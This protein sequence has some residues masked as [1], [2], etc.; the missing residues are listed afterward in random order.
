[1]SK[2][3]KL[4]IAVL[5]VLAISANIA[6]IKHRVNEE[7]RKHEEYIKRINYTIY[8]QAL[9]LCKDEEIYSGDVPDKSI[10]FD[11]NELMMR[12]AYFNGVMG[13]TGE[14]AITTDD[15][16]RYYQ[17][18]IDGDSQNIANFSNVINGLDNMPNENYDGNSINNFIEIV[19]KNLDYDVIT[20]T[21]TPEQLEEAIKKTMSEYETGKYRDA[22]D[23]PLELEDNY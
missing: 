16:K 21:A 18:Y 4:L 20:N 13:Y 8:L 12:V 23:S 9:G 22:V 17:E 5:I 2:K 7:N 3:T 14:E 15:V 6:I 11:E 19:N 1:M 10:K